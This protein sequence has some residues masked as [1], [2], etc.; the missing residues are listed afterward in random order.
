MGRKKINI[1][2]DGL[3]LAHKEDHNDLKK[4]YAQ[5][6]KVINNQNKV[7]ENILQIKKVAK[8]YVIK[9][10]KSIKS[11][12]VAFMIAS[13]WHLEES[14]YPDQVNGLNEFNLDI[15][16]N[17][18]QH[19]FRNGLKLT[20]MLAKENSIQTIVLA[21]LGDFITN[22]LHE[23]AAES[24][25]LSPIEAIMKVQ[26]HLISGINYLLENSNYNIII[27]C[28]TGNHSRTTEKLRI[29]TEY[30]NS[31]ETYMYNNLAQLFKGNKRVEFII[32]R[33]YH[34]FMDVFGYNIC[35][36][37]GHAMKYG[38]GIGGLF[39]PAYK[40][41]ANW[42]IARKADLNIFGHFHQYKDG[43]TFIS[44]GSLI[45]YNPYAIRIKAPYEKPQQT[46][47]LIQK[48][49]GKTITAPIFLD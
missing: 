32:S 3:N 19:F 48:G 9:G 22:T 42:N 12:S 8:S 17:R 41:I 31:L 36:H 18:V 24:N 46:F 28:S 39:I 25:N 45:G 37:H 15:A 1:E 11:E 38:G 35:L 6:L 33:S 10:K 43:G 29:S 44:N 49:R 21:L 23:D 34:T 14:V 5:S 13:D 26:E 27:P 20:N 7:I 47:F 2:Q 30:G 4:K 16:G 40:A